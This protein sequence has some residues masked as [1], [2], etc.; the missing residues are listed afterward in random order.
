MEVKNLIVKAMKEGVTK[1]DNPVKDRVISRKAVAE[2]CGVTTKTISNW[3]DQGFLTPVTIPGKY[4]AVGYRE[5][6]VDALIAGRL[7]DA[8]NGKSLQV[9]E[10]TGGD[11]HG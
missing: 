8:H 11:S 6:D 2:R 3:C 9:T 7:G 10:Q 5:S 1:K 4:R